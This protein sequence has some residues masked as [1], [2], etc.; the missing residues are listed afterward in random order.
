VIVGG[1]TEP[2]GRIVKRAGTRT[3]TA[4]VVVD[5]VAVWVR[6]TVVAVGV[7]GVVVEIDG[8]VNGAVDVDALE[9]DFEPPQPTIASALKRSASLLTFAG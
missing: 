9:V 6:V 8:M 5:L 7:V 1:I 2:S 4:P 3:L